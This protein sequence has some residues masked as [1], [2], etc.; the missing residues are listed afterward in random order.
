[1]RPII[2][3]FPI[4]R[5]YISTD[6]DNGVIADYVFLLFDWQRPQAIFINNI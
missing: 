5:I 6:T 3:R 4:S 2:A 1:M